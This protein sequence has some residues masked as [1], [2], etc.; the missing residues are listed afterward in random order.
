MRKLL[1]DLFLT[2]HAYYDFSKPLYVAA[3]LVELIQRYNQY[4]INEAIEDDK[5]QQLV[6][7]ALG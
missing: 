4:A 3:T 7:A 1:G 2:E 5:R 6:V